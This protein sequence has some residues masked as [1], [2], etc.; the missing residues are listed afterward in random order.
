MELNYSKDKTIGDLQTDFATAF[1]GLKLKFF[2]KPHEAHKGSHAKFLIPDVHT[3]L[4]SIAPDIKSGHVNIELDM[5]VW[6][7]ERLLE[8][9]CQLHTQVFRKSGNVYLE[10]SV[11]DDMTIEQQMAKAKAS[12]NIHQEFV[13][14]LDY[15]E[16]D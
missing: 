13:D 6:Q 9:E 10:T 2:S 5:P 14:P 3:T 12:D 11:S 4:G 1:P 15:R 7:L 16:Q 8:Q